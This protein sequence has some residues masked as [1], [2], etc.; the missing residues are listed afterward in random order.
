VFDLHEDDATEIA[1]KVQL[2]AVIN[3]LIG[4][5]VLHSHFIEQDVPLQ[6]KKE[7]ERLGWQV[8]H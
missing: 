5:Q 1:T 2:D 7:A 4:V 8:A 3:H 6:A